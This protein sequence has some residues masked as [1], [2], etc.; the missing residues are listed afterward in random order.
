MTHKTADHFMHLAEHTWWISLEGTLRIHG[1]VGCLHCLSA[2][3]LFVA[4][5]FDRGL[6]A[7]IQVSLCWLIL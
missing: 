4:C 1:S 7:D 6:R 3:L 5:H 2:A